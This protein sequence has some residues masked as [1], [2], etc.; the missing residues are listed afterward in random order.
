MIWFAW[1][2]QRL[3]LLAA[4]AAVAGIAIWFTIEG[5]HEEA[6]WSCLLDRIHPQGPSLYC[7]AAWTA[8]NF[9]HWNPFFYWVLYAVP[10]LL[11]VLLGAPLVAREFDHKTARIAWTQSVTRAR[12][13]GTKLL[14]VGVVVAA[15]TAGVVAL[16]EWWTGAVRAG[17]TVLPDPFDVTGLAPISYGVFAFLLGAAL[18]AV[19]RR[20]GWTVFVAIP[21]FGLSRALLRFAV[22]PH[23][24]STMTTA[25]PTMTGLGWKQGWVL[26]TGYLPMGQLSPPTGKTWSSWA[27]VAQTCLFRSFVPIG[28]NSR[29]GVPALDRLCLT[30]HRLH[31]VIQ[32]QPQSHYWQLQ[33]EESAIFLVVGFALAAIAFLAVRKRT[34]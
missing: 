23:L 22:R 30:A 33:V 21:L 17:A 19:L 3:Y 2:V 29:M 11:G 34:V 8:Y 16:A 10:G 27:D 9:T 31:Y 15:L 18:G 28:P 20:T 5:R 4:T 32:F 12:W 13:L 24:A 26:N 6:M 25:S 14:F 1:R 7:S